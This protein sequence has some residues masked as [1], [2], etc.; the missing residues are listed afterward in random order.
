MYCVNIS[1]LVCIFALLF[2]HLGETNRVAE[3]FTLRE[4]YIK[5]GDLKTTNI[6]LTLQSAEMQSIT[7]IKDVAIEEFGMIESGE[8]DYIALNK[9]INIV[10]K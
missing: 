2:I 8:R 7:R 1:L 4:L 6:K 9:N 10:K 5:L 3:G